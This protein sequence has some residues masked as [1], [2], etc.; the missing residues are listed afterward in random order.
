MG[1]D[2]LSSMDFGQ[3]LSVPFEKRLCINQKPLPSKV[4][5]F[6]AVALRFLNAKIAPEYGFCFNSP[7]QTP[8]KESIPLRK[9]MG[10]I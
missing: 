10:F 1:V 2:T 8:I 6:M 4:N 5:N 9:S 7:R 3:Y